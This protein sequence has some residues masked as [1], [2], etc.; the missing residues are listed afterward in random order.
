MPAIRAAWGVVPGPQSPPP[1]GQPVGDQLDD[2]VARRGT[3]SRH[4]SS[5][6][7]RQV[8]APRRRDG[9]LRPRSSEAAPSSHQLDVGHLEPEGA[10]SQVEPPGPR[11][12][13]QWTAE[14]SRH[15]AAQPARLRPGSPGR[16]AGDH[17][18]AWPARG[19][20]RTTPRVGCRRRP[21]PSRDRRSRCAR[22][23]DRG[24]ISGPRHATGRGRGRPRA[25]AGSRRHGR[26]CARTSDRAVGAVAVGEGEGVHL[27]LGGPLDERL[28]RMGRAPYWRGSS[29]TPR[30]RWTKGSMPALHRR[31]GVSR[32]RC[33]RPG[34][35]HSWGERRGA[36]Q[37]QRL[38]DHGEEPVGVAD[39]VVGLALGD[40][41]GGAGLGGGPLARRRRRRTRPLRQLGSHLG[42]QHPGVLLAPPARRRRRARAASSAAAARSAATW[43]QA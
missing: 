1:A 30:G 12:P 25:P 18:R 21:V 42:Q 28:V 10:S 29:P 6:A 2:E 40:R 8:V 35:R 36:D 19:T 34:E 33:A 11:S 7:R 20:R 4:G 43:A 15:T 23:S 26:P 39:Q 14:T 13:G 17:G 31:P 32:R 41:A 16:P 38:L 27:L 3:S 22:S 37:T 9:Q 24:R 5:A